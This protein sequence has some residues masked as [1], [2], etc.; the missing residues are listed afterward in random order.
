[1]TV[2]IETSTAGIRFAELPAHAEEVRELL[3]SMSG[4]PGTWPKV[5]PFHL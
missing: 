2:A 3:F 5:Y 1:M 4:G